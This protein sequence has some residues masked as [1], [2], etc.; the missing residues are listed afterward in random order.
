MLSKNDVITKQRNELLDKHH[1]R[2]N[3]MVSEYITRGG[4]VF[5]AKGKPEKIGFIT[6]NLF[7]LHV[8]RMVQRG[9]LV[10]AHDKALGITWYRYP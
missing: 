10:A 9:E 8:K 5:D 6:S 7:M 1:D 4:G 3:E 2:M